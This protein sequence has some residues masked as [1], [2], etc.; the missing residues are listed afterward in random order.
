MPN[1]PRTIVRLMKL[2]FQFASGMFV[3]SPYSVAV[4]AGSTIP[5]TISWSSQLPTVLTPT[6]SSILRAAVITLMKPGSQVCRNWIGVGREPTVAGA[7]NDE[8]IA[9]AELSFSS[10]T[11]WRTVA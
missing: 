7:T 11:C 1:S 6:M 9:P 5:C 2:V 10:L 4:A 3:K 8:S